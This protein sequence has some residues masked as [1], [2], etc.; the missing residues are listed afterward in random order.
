MN[1]VVEIKEHKSIFR[2]AS[3]LGLA[4]VA[5]LGI[6]SCSSVRNEK[7]AIETSQDPWLE[8][9]VAPNHLSPKKQWI[10]H[11]DGYITELNLSQ[12]GNAV[13]VATLPD[14]DHS[15]GA[16]K[17]RLRYFDAQGHERW[18]QVMPT[19]VKSQA[20][21]RDGSLAIATT[22]ED[23]VLAFDSK[24]NKLWTAHATCMPFLIESRKEIVCYHDD[25]AEP[26]VAFD[27]FDWN[28]KL[29]RSFPIK[30]DILALKVSKDQQNIAIALTRGQVFLLGPD[31]EVRWNGNVAGEI[32]DID[33]AN[34]AAPQVAVL[35]ASGLGKIQKLTVFS[36]AKAQS[37]SDLEEQFNQIS[38]APDAKSVFAYGNRGSGQLIALFQ[39]SPVKPLWGHRIENNSHYTQTMFISG[40]AQPKLV[41]AILGVEKVRGGS[42]QSEVV[43]LDSSGKLLWR[44]PVTSSLGADEGAFLYAQ[45]LASSVGPTVQKLAISTDDRKFGVFE[46]SVAPS[47]SP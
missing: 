46:L 1:K 4:G 40:L 33:V 32:V 26:L 42:R 15:D 12:S 14:Y 29:K 27:V 45:S 5:A 17:N 18:S 19:Q 23:Q 47:N 3:V 13:L 20:L 6:Y 8:T 9:D 39:S 37:E 30:N 36:K 16:K 7:T 25:D 10:R 2:I 41:Q 22:H 34:G 44:I 38:F 43:G 11:L 28:G 24:G 31:Y 21:S 35:S